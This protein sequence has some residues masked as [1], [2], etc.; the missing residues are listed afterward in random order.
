MS[1]LDLQAGL[2]LSFL[3][4]KLDARLLTDCIKKLLNSSATC[5]LSVMMFSPILSSYLFWVTLPFGF[6]RQI[7]LPFPL[8]SDRA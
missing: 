6:S 4:G 8:A 2:L 1:Y 5:A 7:I 3:L